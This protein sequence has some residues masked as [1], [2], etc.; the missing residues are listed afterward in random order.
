MSNYL[1]LVETN[2]FDYKPH[3][4]KAAVSGQRRRIFV[5]EPNERVL[6]Y[7]QRVLD[8]L[9]HVDV[10]DQPSSFVKAFSKSRTPDLT[11]LAWSSTERSAAVL[12][13]VMARSRNHPILLA[14]AS[15]NGEEMARAFTLGA[16]GVIQKPFHDG[17]LKGAVGSY[18][19][20]STHDAAES[21]AHEET[22][23]SEGYSFVRSSKRMR[24]IETSAALVAR[25]EIPVLVLGESGTGKEILARYLHAKSNRSGGMFLKLNCAAMPADLL[26][27][28]LFGYEK[29]AFTGA[30]QTK[31]GKFEI[32]RGGTIF[33]DEIGEMP[34]VLQAKLLH[35]LQDGTYSRLGG[36]ST[37]RADVRVVAATNIDMKAAIVQKTFRED[38]YYRLNG[39]TLALPPLRERRD[40]IAVFAQHFMQKGAAKYGRPQL[41]LGGELLEALESHAWPGNLRELENV[42]NRYL[43]I[44]DARSIIEELH[45]RMGLQPVSIDTQDGLK[46]RMRSLKGSAEAAAIVRMLEETKWNRKAAAARMKVS[47][48]TLLYKIQQYELGPPA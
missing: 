30:V 23:L 16:S 22:R 14:S 13:Q 41:A 15:A 48:R 26:E 5:H 4:A 11:L 39:F 40:E 17:D 44:G 34:A 7:M 21:V 36:R 29:G 1:S 32:C 27:S 18:V 47:Y 46:Q 37:L 31:P 2:V 28:E 25:S 38:L 42:I 6:R 35:V 33:L 8:P 9:Y 24:D 10:F 45:P 20:M 43:I 3:L 12:E 19:R